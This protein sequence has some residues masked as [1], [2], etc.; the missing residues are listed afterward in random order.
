MRPIIRWLALVA[1]APLTPVFAS[2]QELTEPEHR[3]AAAVDAAVADGLA[4]LER[5]VN[6]N[7]GTMNFDGVREV[8]S[9]FRT[10][11]ERLGFAT[12]WIDG[13]EWTRAGHL[14]A[15][16]AGEAG[17]PSV[18]FIGHLDTVFETDSP[19]QR[20]HRLS[21]S[22]AAGPGVV[23]MKGGIV[24]M[25]LA[26][27]ALA[28]I[29]AVDR[30]SFTVVLTGDEERA[31]RP[32]S[33]AR[34]DLREA[35]E[36]ADV[37]I[38]FEDGDGDPTTAVI[39]RRGATTWRLHTEGRPAHSSQIFREDIGSGAI[40]EMARILTAFHDSL[41]GE[42][43]LTFN[44]GAVVGGTTADVDAEEGRGTAT[45]KMNV[46]AQT[47]EVIGDLRAL[48]IEQR[49]RAKTEMDRIVAEHLP[50]TSAKIIFDDAYPPLAPTE[51]NRRLLA[52]F[53]AS[54]RD[55]GFGPVEAV[56]PAR[57]G[58]A[59]VSFTAG[60]VDMAIDGVGLMGDGGHT[61]DEIADLRT[62][63][64]QAKRVAIALWRLSGE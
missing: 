14:V 7:S 35:A 20:F 45:G 62:L 55:L 13:S 53:D 33:L 49:D 58:A 52:M 63:P 34:R 28:E 26:L 50:H 29:D 59:D 2:A 30:L 48:S 15:E 40:Y 24:V 4:L 18:L 56:D 21:D 54:S 5:S 17:A 11:F 10:E 51:G 19:F 12:R 3:I 42:E 27:Q 23:D 64:I 60:L 8:G 32:I 1:L 57:A 43:F 41:G 31:G 16:R 6:I 61:V 22:T 44:P 46:I 9:L 36:R 38:G 47:C 39:A 25:L 37:A